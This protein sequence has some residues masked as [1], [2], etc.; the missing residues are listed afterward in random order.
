MSHLFIEHW[1]YKA[2]SLPH[3]A[4]SLK[5]SRCIY[6]VGGGNCRSFLM[7]VALKEEMKLSTESEARKG[8]H[9]KHEE[10]KLV[11]TCPLGE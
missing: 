11:W 4:F 5:I 2:K 6:Y 8:I 9:W 10:R 3:G 7:T 1:R